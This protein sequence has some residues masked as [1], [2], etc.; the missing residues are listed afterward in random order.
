MDPG[1]VHKGGGIWQHTKLA[2]TAAWTRVI[3]TNLIS[4]WQ[5][6]AAE[7]ETLYC[8][9]ALADDSLI[10]L[11]DALYCCTAAAE[12]GVCGV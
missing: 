11:A 3:H 7:R 8:L 10:Q 5:T 2:T 1:I 6:A 4:L 12:R 9:R